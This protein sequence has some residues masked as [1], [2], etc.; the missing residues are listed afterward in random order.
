[1]IEQYAGD[2]EEEAWNAITQAAAD[3]V[4]GWQRLS[5]SNVVLLASGMA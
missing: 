3:A 1:M 2:A 5:F 4:G